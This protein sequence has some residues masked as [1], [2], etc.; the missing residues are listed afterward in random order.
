VHTLGVVPS[1]RSVRN[2]GAR[3]D[4]V[5]RAEGK[6]LQLVQ[7]LNTPK[8]NLYGIKYASVLLGFMKPDISDGARE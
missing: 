7:P 5:L 4:G 3:V 2:R 8:L 1:P 6:L